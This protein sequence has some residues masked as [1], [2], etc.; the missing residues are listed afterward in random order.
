MA[1]SSYETIGSF[2][3]K[4]RGGGSWPIRIVFV[5]E[6][7]GG[8]FRFPHLRERIIRVDRADWV[9]FDEREVEP[10]HGVRDS[11]KKGKPGHTEMP[12]ALGKLLANWRSLME[13][14]V[15]SR[16]DRAD[17]KAGQKR[18]FE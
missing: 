11:A 8:H 16:E 14:A 4:R 2:E 1:G 13:K 18:L 17:R 6:A 10:E 5:F 3:R 15:E 12:S 7:M 9:G